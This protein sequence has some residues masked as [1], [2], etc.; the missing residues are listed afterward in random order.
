VDDPAFRA[1]TRDACANVPGND[2][3]LIAER[4]RDRLAG[5]YRLVVV[6]A[7]DPLAADT[8]EL[9]LYAFRDGA[10]V[11]SRAPLPVPASS[12]GMPRG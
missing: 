10:A 5:R 9:V 6:R 4:V 7:Q 12:P 11:P 1:A 8:N 2:P 3:V